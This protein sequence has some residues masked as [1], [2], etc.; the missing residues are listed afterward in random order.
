MLKF[1]CHGD[2]ALSAL[3]IILRQDMVRIGF[4]DVLL[5][6]IRGWPCVLYC[7]MCQALG[8]LR[9]KKKERKEKVSS[10]GYY[11]M[12]LMIT[13]LCNSIQAKSLDMNISANG[14]MYLRQQHSF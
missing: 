11:S 8:L 5:L 6:S 1:L 10:M 13:L 3:P 2:K 12:I 4:M 9:E 7:W 14:N